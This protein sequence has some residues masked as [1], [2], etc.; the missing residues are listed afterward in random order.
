VLRS[1]VRSPKKTRVQ[2]VDEY[3]IGNRTRL[4]EIAAFLDCLDRAGQGA[5]PEADFRM[6]AFREALSVLADGQASRT[7]R[8]KVER[9]ARRSPVP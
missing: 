2:L 8:L 3:F 4:L 9:A 5:A 1:D 6:R 7:Q